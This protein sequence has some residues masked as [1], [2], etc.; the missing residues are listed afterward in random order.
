MNLRDGYHNRRSLLCARRW[1]VIEESA[2]LVIGDDY[3]T[4]PETIGRPDGVAHTCNERLSGSDIRRWMIVGCRRQ[5]RDVGKVRFNE[6]YPRQTPRAAQSRIETDILVVNRDDA[7]IV[8]TIAVK[9]SN[10][11]Q[12]AFEQSPLDPVRRQHLEYASTLEIA[13]SWIIVFE[14]HELRDRAH[15][16]CEAV[17]PRGSRMRREPAV[18]HQERV[19][20]LVID[21]QLAFPIHGH[22]KLRSVVNR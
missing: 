15:D 2:V 18:A 19:S 17:W 10:E 3:Q 13:Y 22:G 12:I 21:R 14:V 1:Y 5:W 6:H 7:L 4:V 8:Q 11:R 20:E 16:R 9:H